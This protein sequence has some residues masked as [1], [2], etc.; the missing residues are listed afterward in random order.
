MIKKVVIFEKSQNPDIGQNTGDQIPLTLFALAPVDPDPGIIIDQNR[1]G[2]NQNVIRLKDHVKPTAGSQK[3]G[4]A[5]FLRQQKISGGDHR[6]KD[7]KMNRVKKY[8][9]QQRVSSLIF[10]GCFGYYK[11]KKF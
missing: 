10:P 9:R 6:E 7:Q 8:S 11:G 2:E 4:P 1:K 5:I 3:P